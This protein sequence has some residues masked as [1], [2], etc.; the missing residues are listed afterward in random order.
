[1]TLREAL[2]QIPDPRASNRQYPLWSLLALIL[3]A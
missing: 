2:S 1:M 3:V